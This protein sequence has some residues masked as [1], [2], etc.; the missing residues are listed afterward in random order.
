MKLEFPKEDDQITRDMAHEELKRWLLLAC[1][2][3]G[4]CQYERQDNGRYTPGEKKHEFTAQDCAVRQQAEW[5]H[6]SETGRQRDTMI[7]AV[8]NFEVVQNRLHV[9]LC[10]DTDTHLFFEKVEQ[11]KIAEPFPQYIRDII[12]DI[13]NRTRIYVPQVFATHLRKHEQGLHDKIYMHDDKKKIKYWR[14][15]SVGYRAWAW[16]R[17]LVK[18]IFFDALTK[19]VTRSSVL[20]SLLQHPVNDGDRTEIEQQNQ[21]YRDM[22]ADTKDTFGA[23]E[24]KKYKIEENLHL[25]KNQVVLTVFCKKQRPLKKKIPEAQRQVSCCEN[26]TQGNTSRYLL[27]DKR[28][29]QALLTDKKQHPVKELD[30]LHYRSYIFLVSTDTKNS[31][32]S[33]LSLKD[34]VY[35]KYPLQEVDSSEKN[36]F[37]TCWD[38]RTYSCL[39]PEYLLSPDSIETIQILTDR[40][41]SE[42]L[43]KKIKTNDNWPSTAHDDLEA[44]KYICRDTTNKRA[45]FEEKLDPF[46]K[47]STSSITE[48]EQKFM[49]TLPDIFKR[50]NIVLDDYN[51]KLKVDEWN[52]LEFLK[53]F[54][55]VDLTTKSKLMNKLRNSSKYI[56]TNSE[57][58]DKTKINVLDINDNFDEPFKEIMTTLRR[59]ILPKPNEDT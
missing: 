21:L 43:F 9:A 58:R 53:E 13:P 1:A 44:C 10:D 18:S 49:Y 26:I 22:L 36:Y 28:M 57:E 47:H 51:S 54:L 46:I 42:A 32:N 2:R 24:L 5:P 17:L 41:N 50:H 16:K 55:R 45:Y 11:H 27:I 31:Q 34:K 52:D 38:C 3:P 6:T 59:R 12:T 37:A 7:A 25:K 15:V 23:L 33:V 56:V 14:M 19:V 8:G 29:H 4:H 35:V 20:L 48:N 40:A 30:V 39:K